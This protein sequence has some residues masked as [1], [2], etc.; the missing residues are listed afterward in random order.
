MTP[1][2][3]NEIIGALHNMNYNQFKKEREEAFEERY[4][5][6]NENPALMGKGDAFQA[7]ENGRTELL[8]YLLENGPSSILSLGI[9]ENDLYNKAVKDWHTFLKG[10]LK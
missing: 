3:S 2:P 10:L 5:W 4:K 8:N 7:V 6:A 9:P 1:T